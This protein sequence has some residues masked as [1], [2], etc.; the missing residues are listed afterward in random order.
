MNPLTASLTALVIVDGPNVARTVAGSRSRS[1]RQIPPLDMET[2]SVALEAVEERFPGVPQEV[3]L[4]Q[5]DY[6]QLDREDNK[7]F[8]TIQ[9]KC[10]SVPSRSDV[11]EVILQ[12]ALKLRK[13]GVPVRILT[14][15]NYDVYREKP[16]RARSPAAGAR[17]PSTLSGEVGGQQ[18]VSSPKSIGGVTKEWLTSVLW[19]F[20]ISAV[21][22]SCILMPVDDFPSSPVLA[23][24]AAGHDQHALLPRSS[25]QMSCTMTTSGDVHYEALGQHQMS[26]GGDL[27]RSIMMNS[28]VL[29]TPGGPASSNPHQVTLD[30]HADS[31]GE[32]MEVDQ[33]EDVSSSSY[34]DQRGHPENEEEVEIYL[35]NG[36]DEL[37]KKLEHEKQLLRLQVEQGIP[38]VLVTAANN[39]TCE[40]RGATAASAAIF[41]SSSTGNVGPVAG[42]ARASPSNVGLSEDYD[43]YIAKGG[44]PMTTAGTSSH[45]HATASSSS[46]SSGVIAGIT[47]NKTTVNVAL[48]KTLGQR[49][50]LASGTSGASALARAKKSSL[51][52][53]HGTST[54]SGAGAKSVRKQGDKIKPVEAAKRNVK[55]TVGKISSSATKAS[56]PGGASSA[57]TRAA[58]T[59][60]RAKAAASSTNVTTSTTATAS[61]GGTT[62]SSSSSTAVAASMQS[63]IGG[64]IHPAN[65]RMGNAFI[66]DEGNDAAPQKD[67]TK[68]LRS[69]P[70]RTNSASALASGAKA[71]GSRASPSGVDAWNP[72]TWAKIKENHTSNSN[73]ASC[74][75]NKG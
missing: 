11:D 50:P 45:A 8:R 4:Y 68:G 65:A 62:T 47:T 64:H 61:A 29:L 35:E 13:R 46:S 26:V 36:F 48:N 3:M 72:E 23:S 75:R 43:Y 2:L 71:S 14:N 40:N 10:T 38:T 1:P 67:P 69:L 58:G 17:G 5:P 39:G 24:G 55:A 19:K 32:D 9:R 7:T 49:L 21:D 31:G 37:R 60:T 53:A 44:L 34:N 63:R 41:G 54:A 25:S 20:S 27:A 6:D 74:R 52:A 16:A 56:G 57:A 73:S 15:D 30:H 18:V 51:A 70:P 12:R 33:M 28:N 59:T 66:V 22:R 42:S